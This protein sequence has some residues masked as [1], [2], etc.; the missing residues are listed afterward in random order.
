MLGSLHWSSYRTHIE[1]YTYM[2]S[3]V[4]T[5]MY[6]L[7]GSNEQK[8][9][10]IALYHY[11]W[12]PNRDSNASILIK[13]TQTYT[14]LPS[15]HDDS[16]LWNY[17]SEWLLRCTSVCFIKFVALESWSG[18]REKLYN[19]TESRFCSFDP[20]RLYELWKNLFVRVAM[21]VYECSRPA[22][23]DGSH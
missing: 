17:D 12:A 4:R 13:N 7:F 19:A 21:V 11:S 5:H 20:K 14:P 15:D 8:H 9:D 3:S 16:M 10:S 23:A 18:T 6:S 2:Y 22:Q 1:L